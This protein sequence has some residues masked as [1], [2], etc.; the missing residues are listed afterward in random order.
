[1]VP[2][3]NSK[4]WIAKFKKEKNLCLPFQA[5]LSAFSK[6]VEAEDV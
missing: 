3:E 5:N 6:K 4:A 1:L 2:P